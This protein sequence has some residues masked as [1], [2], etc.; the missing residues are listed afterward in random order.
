MS[1]GTQAPSV[2][3]IRHVQYQYQHPSS[4]TGLV[5][6]RLDNSNDE[7]LRKQRRGV[8]QPHQIEP[9]PRRVELAGLC[10]WCGSRARRFQAER[11]RPYP[12]TASTGFTLICWLEVSASGTVHTGGDVVVGRLFFLLMVSFGF[13]S[14]LGDLRAAVP[15]SGQNTQSSSSLPQKR[16]C[17]PKRVKKTL[18]GNTG[19]PAPP[20]PAYLPTSPFKVLALTRIA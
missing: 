18:F 13:S 7:D 17:G 2:H 11:A 14:S 1:I 16:G 3:Q 15:F 6:S 10:R 12:T 19:P 5:I 4:S 9:R 8:S 20:T